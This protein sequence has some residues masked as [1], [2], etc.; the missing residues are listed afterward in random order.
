MQGGAYFE[1]LR[2]ADRKAQDII[3][4]AYADKSKKKKQVEIEVKQQVAKIR[5]DLEKKILGSEKKEESSEEQRKKL[6][7]E[8]NQELQK[9]TA[10]A[11][12]KRDE[13]MG[14]VLYFTAQTSAKASKV[15]LQAYQQKAMTALA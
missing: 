5:Q 14:I 6:Q 10:R 13:A 9:L 15:N 8:T 2:E 11:Q 1:K 12:A 4:K 3:D 7:E